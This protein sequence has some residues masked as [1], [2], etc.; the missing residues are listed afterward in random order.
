MNPCEC[1]GTG[2][3]SRSRTGLLRISELIMSPS[4]VVKS[5]SDW[6]I[7]I[8]MYRLREKET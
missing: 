1:P 6:A 5:S 3:S 2:S 4:F 8:N 7:Y